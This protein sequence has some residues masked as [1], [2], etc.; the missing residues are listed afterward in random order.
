M[1]FPCPSTPV[2]PAGEG[3]PEEALISGCSPMVVVIPVTTGTRI[4]FLHRPMNSPKDTTEEASTGNLFK[5][6]LKA[7]QAPDLGL[8]APATTRGQ[9]GLGDLFMPWEQT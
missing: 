3:G 7:L 1:S 4:W 6:K 5:G 9:M 8:V 2:Q